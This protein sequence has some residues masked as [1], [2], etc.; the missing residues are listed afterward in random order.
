MLVR[1][2]QNS[3]LLP[4]SQFFKTWKVIQISWYVYDLSPL[5]VFHKSNYNDLS[6]TSTA[7]K[8]NFT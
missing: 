8:L 4:S 6:V 7:V 3:E 2:P 5:S 1:Q